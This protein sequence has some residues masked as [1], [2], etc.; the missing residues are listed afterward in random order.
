LHSGKIWAESGGL[1]R[2]STFSVGLPLSVAITSPTP[3]TVGHPN[4]ASRH[5][6]LLLVEDSNDVRFL[7]KQEL[8]WAGHEVFAAMDGAIALEIAKREK[9]DMIISDIK[10]PNVDGYQFIKEVRD[11]PELAKIPAI[12]MTGFGMER[13]VEQARAAGYDAHL[14]KPVDIDDMSRLIQKLATDPHLPHS[15]I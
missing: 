7:I 1:R 3:P 11:I 4:T 14:V 8:E 2:G 15:G 9:P 5:L 13:D 10:M 6:R 12:A